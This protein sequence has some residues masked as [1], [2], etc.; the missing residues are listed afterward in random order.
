MLSFGRNSSSSRPSSIQGDRE[1]DSFDNASITRQKLDTTQA[2]LAPPAAANHVVSPVNESPAREMAA[3]AEAVGPSPLGQAIQTTGSEQADATSPMGYVPPPLVDSSIGNPGAF[4]DQTDELPQ[5]LA[6][7]DPFM[8]PKASSVKGPPSSYAPSVHDIPASVPVSKSHGQEPPTEPESE[9]SAP[10]DVPLVPTPPPQVIPTG[11]V[12]VAADVPASIPEPEI[13]LVPSASEPA[14]I[15]V[16][17]RPSTPLEKP[18]S[19]SSYFDPSRSQTSG[20]DISHTV[21]VN[22]VSIPVLPPVPE[23]GRS[24]LPI[25]VDITEIHPMPVP[26]HEQ[27]SVPSVDGENVPLREPIFRA[28]PVNE[29]RSV[30]ENWGQGHRD[31][32]EA[33]G[34]AHH[35]IPSIRCVFSPY[36]RWQVLIRLPGAMVTLTR[37]LPRL[38]RGSLCR[39]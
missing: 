27:S 21:E 38:P 33:N 31:E 29:L 19:A 4:T 11:D 2:T 7:S 13:A 6:V 8:P 28:L 24:V 22:P 16:P 30:E 14:Q 35:D 1:R 3:E 39:T 36:T 15:Y 10:R 25:P 37:F 18:D 34:S 26:V 5:P 32:P 12:P 20:H 9:P 23:S 17:E